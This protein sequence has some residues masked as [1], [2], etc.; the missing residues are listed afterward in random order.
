M[1]SGLIENDDAVGARFDGPRDFR[2]VERYGV[3]VAARHHQARAFAL[4]SSPLTKSALD[5]ACLL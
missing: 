5:E 4:L 2:R 1:P 3:G